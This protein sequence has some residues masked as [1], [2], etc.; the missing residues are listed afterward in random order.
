MA[1]IRSSSNIEKIYMF[2]SISG[3]EIIGEGSKHVV[4]EYNEFEK[5]VKA[6]LKGEHR[7]KTV[8]ISN[9]ELKENEDIITINN[10]ILNNN[11]K[12]H[13][14]Q[15]NISD[16]TFD[17]IALSF[18]YNISYIDDKLTLKEIFH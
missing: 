18:L 9:I 8:K 4:C 10:V 3:L 7:T 13:D 1:I 14:K 15:F 2:Q 11:L 17:S 12:I 5:I 16:S 6:Y